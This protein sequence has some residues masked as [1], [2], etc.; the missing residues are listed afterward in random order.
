MFLKTPFVTNL[1]FSVKGRYAPSSFSVSQTSL[2][3]FWTYHGIISLLQYGHFILKPP[4]LQIFSSDIFL[5][6][7]SIISYKP[8]SLFGRMKALFADTLSNKVCLKSHP[9]TKHYRKA[10]P[11]SRKCCRKAHAHIRRIACNA[12]RPIK[13]RIYIDAQQRKQGSFCK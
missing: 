12:A 3:P 4:P 7:F 8:L 5:L 11:E 10:N 1:P 13:K 2:L 6:C 9:S